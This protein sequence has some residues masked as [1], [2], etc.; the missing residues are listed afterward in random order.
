MKEKDLTI[1]LLK[2]SAQDKDKYQSDVS[3]QAN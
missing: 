2:K 1:S 3:N